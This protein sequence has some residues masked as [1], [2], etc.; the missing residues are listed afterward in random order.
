MPRESHNKAKFSLRTYGIEA[1]RP[2]K[3]LYLAREH[4]LAVV[5]SEV[6]VATMAKTS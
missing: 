3:Q 5:K 2:V 4:Y 6:Q 1:S